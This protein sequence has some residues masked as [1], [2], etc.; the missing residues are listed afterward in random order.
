[1]PYVTMTMRG[2]FYF[3]A[4]LW[5]VLTTRFIAKAPPINS[6][7]SKCHTKKLKSSSTC[8]IGYSGFILRE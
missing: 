7:D 1:M 4:V 6:I 3:Y 8:L 5:Q 2:D